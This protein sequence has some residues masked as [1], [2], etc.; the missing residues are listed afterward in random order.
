MLFL[1]HTVGDNT[2]DR[3]NDQYA[4]GDGTGNAAGFT[5]LGCEACYITADGEVYRIVN[6]C[7]WNQR[8]E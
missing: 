1:V 8:E 4:D 2:D 6:A 7:S 3:R 5:Q